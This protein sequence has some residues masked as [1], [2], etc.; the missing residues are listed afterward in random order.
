MKNT[1][2]LYNQILLQLNNYVL[3]NIIQ[4]KISNS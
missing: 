3:V 4:Y 1:I 2:K